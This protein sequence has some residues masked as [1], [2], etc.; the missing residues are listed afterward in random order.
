M[1][2]K[3]VLVF[4]ALAFGLLLPACRHSTTDDASTT[5]ATFVP[6]S[7]VRG[8]IPYEQADALTAD[9]DLTGDMDI[10]STGEFSVSETTA[11]IV[12]SGEY[13][14]VAPDG[15]EVAPPWYDMALTFDYDD[16]G[17]LS[18]QV[19]STGDY[20]Q[21][22]R[23]VY[24]FSDQG[25]FTRKSVFFADNDDDLLVGLIVTAAADGDA[26]LVRWY[27]YFG[28]NITDP[29]HDVTGDEAIGSCRVYRDDDGNMIQQVLY[30][31][32]EPDE[33]EDWN[34]TAINLYEYD[35]EGRLTKM[36]MHE[37]GGGFDGDFDSL[38]PESA[39]Y[40]RE[41]RGL[42]D[43]KGNLKYWVQ[44]EP[45]DDTCEVFM[46]TWEEQEFSTTAARF[47]GSLHWFDMRPFEGYG[48]RSLYLL[49]FPSLVA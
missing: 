23:L 44:V 15:A 41:Y 17:Y 34:V 38:S 39:S 45:G 20:A 12:L 40:R 36:S 8:Y 2:I 18:S 35:G 29:D 30:D 33:Y 46:V 6:A 42:Y 14:E 13:D 26:E 27:N 4:M 19:L 25:T 48:S 32:S 37:F 28:E 3:R 16:Q 9:D 24:T 43:V 22:T 1:H 7:A 47:L 21:T 5:G 49:I 11:G 10:S 31:P